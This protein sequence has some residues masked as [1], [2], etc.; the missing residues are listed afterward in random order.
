MGEVGVG[1]IRFFKYLSA[2]LSIGS[3]YLIGRWSTIAGFT[4]AGISYSSLFSLF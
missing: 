3:G 2:V 1:S 4:R